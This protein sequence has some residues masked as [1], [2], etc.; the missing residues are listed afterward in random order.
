MRNV[1]DFQNLH[2]GHVMLSHMYAVNTSLNTCQ[3]MEVLG[4]LLSGINYKTLKCEKRVNLM[5]AAN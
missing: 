3:W 5:A 2:S 4:E 1:S